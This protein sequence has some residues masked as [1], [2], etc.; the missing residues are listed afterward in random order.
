MVS[1]GRSVFHDRLWLSFSA[2]LH[3][4]G[5]TCGWTRLCSPAGPFELYGDFI[6]HYQCT[7][8]VLRGLSTIVGG[9]GLSLKPLA[10]LL[11]I[12]IHSNRAVNYSNKVVISCKKTLHIT[13]SMSDSQFS[14]GKPLDPQTSLIS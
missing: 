11:K 5:Q 1:Q 9:G 4:R 12:E 6:S 3:A 7:Q 10:P 14:G 2:G 8:G 13:D